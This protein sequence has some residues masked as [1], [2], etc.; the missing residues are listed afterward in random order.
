[1]NS[2]GMF[3]PGKGEDEQ[4]AYKT[5]LEY[6]I[7]EF[8]SPFQE[9]IKSQVA[10]SILLLLCTLI[11]LIWVSVPVLSHTYHR[12]VHA[13]I[14]FHV[15]HLFVAKP[16]NFWVNDVFLAVFFFFVGLEIK[17]EFLVGELTHKKRA[18]MVLMGALGGLIVPA[19]IFCL[20]NV[21]TSAAKGWAIPI[22][23]DTAFALGILSCFKKRLPS[24][25]LTFVAAMAIVDD[26]ASILVIATCYTPHVNIAM[27]LVALGLSFCLV[28]LNYSGF[29]RAWP[30]L[31]IGVFVWLSIESSGVHGT[32]AGILIAFI[33]PARPEKGPKQFLER[34]RSLL[35]TFEKRKDETALILEDQKQHGVLEEVRVI[36]RQATTPLQR[37]VSKLDLPV[38]L[39]ILPLFALVNAGIP[40]TLSLMHEVLTNTLS[41][42]IILGLVVGKPLGIMLFSWLT[43]RMGIGER[44]SSV[45]I[46]QQWQ[47]SVLAGI[48]FTMSLFI[49]D[50]S[51]VNPETL[52]L[53][54]A[55]VLLASLLA[56]LIGF[57]FVL[58]FSSPSSEDGCRP[59]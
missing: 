19:I 23:T 53:V 54:K 51:F 9:Y 39:I 22:A 15:G 37:W 40:V 35:K 1:M 2:S 11:A 16:L 5:P 43:D 26:I 3:H 7:K 50:L 18:F 20:L 32:V 46:T 48:G 14:G 55:A 6:R 49:A 44:P 28:M 29:R 38:A 58:F 59:L 36:A 27:L 41:L 33:I 31:I 34:T 10:A 30:Y 57:C 24:A 45:T 4:H 17:R 8:L 52:L 25:L 47:A 12:F 13:S 42:G 56:G 21:G